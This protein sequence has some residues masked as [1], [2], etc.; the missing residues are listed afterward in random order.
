MTRFCQAKQDSRRAASVALGLW[1][2][3]GD[4]SCINWEY[5]LVSDTAAGVIRSPAC[6]PGGQPTAP[7]EE[8]GPVTCYALSPE[9]GGSGP[10]LVAVDLS[11]GMVKEV[12]SWDNLGRALF[13]LEGMGYDGR[14]LLAPLYEGD[15]F[16]WYLLDPST[17]TALFIGVTEYMVG[18]TWTGSAWLAKDIMGGLGRYDSL[19][20][21]VSGQPTCFLEDGSDSRFAAAGGRLYSS[22]SSAKVVS[23]RNLDTGGL[24]RVVDIEE[25]DTNSVRGLSV[26]GGA[27]HV[28]RGPGRVTPEITSFDLTTGKLV[29]RRSVPDRMTSGLFCTTQSL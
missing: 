28:L 14:A 11:S 20:A 25:D 19:D 18:A 23:V 6:S 24:L 9:L 7:P 4:T 29:G 3:L 22:S 21:L 12:A 8:V 26:A 2:L 1:V 10:A 16:S 17:R 27:I 15:G 13:L 5:P